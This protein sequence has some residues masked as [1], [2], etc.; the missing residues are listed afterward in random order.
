MT[1]HHDYT[2]TSLSMYKFLKI[3]IAITVWINANA[4]AIPA[5]ISIQQGHMGDVIKLAI[6]TDSKY[7][8]TYG[9]D[10][11][12]IIWDY[13]TSS[14]M[15]FIYVP[16]KVDK[17]QFGE[18]LNNLYYAANNSST[19]YQLTIATME[20]KAVSTAN[21]SF[22]SKTE[23]KLP[24][25]LCKIKGAKITWTEAT[26]LKKIKTLT[27]DY[28]DQPY[29]SLVY[30]KDFDYTIAS[31]KDGSIYVYDKNF[32]L[33]KQLKGHN[34]DVNDIALSPD[35][36][37]LYSVSTD[38]SI[39][40]W[41]LESLTMAERYSG[42]NYPAYGLSLNPS[43][44]KLMY[45]DELG[46]LK[47]VNLSSFKLE[48]TSISESQFPIIHSFQFTDSQYLFAG[49]ANKL[50]V[51][52]DTDKRTT[53]RNAGIG[54]KP[55]IHYLFNEKLGLYQPPFSYYKS[56]DVN[57]TAKLLAVSTDIH[58]IIPGY[59]RLYSLNGNK[60]SNKTRKLYT[61]GESNPATVFFLSDSILF[62]SYS[63]TS[64]KLWKVD[65]AKL[66]PV[67]E[68][69]LKI[70]MA[71]AMV[72]RFSN[73]EL[74]VFNKYE[75]FVHNL[76][77][78]TYSSVGT[79]QPTALF[80][81]ADNLAAY[82]TVQNDFFLVSKAKDSFAVLGPF[83]GHQDNITSI[84]YNPEKQQIY[85]S[86]I[87]GSIKIWDKNNME[88]ILTVVAIG[89][90]N[91]I[92]ITPD[93][94]YM[95]SNK[96]LAS[97]G[98]KKE[99]KFYFPEQFDPIY[100]RPDIVLDRLGYADQTLIDAYYRA[101]QKRLKKLGFTEEML[102]NDF[103][104]PTLEL[105]NIDNIQS[106]TDTASIKLDLNATDTKY[107]LDRINVWVN[108]VAAFGTNGVSVKNA[109]TNKV[110][111]E[112]T[113]SLAK[114]QNKIEVSSVNQAGAES[115]KE[116]FTINCTAGKS[117]PDLYIITI[118]VSTYSDERFN[119]KYAAKDATDMIEAFKNNPSFEKVYAKTLTNQEVTIENIQ[120]L[121]AFLAAADIND[122][123][124]V[125]VAG[126]GLLDSK[127]DYYYA[128]YDMDFKNPETKGIPYEAIED[129]LD[130]IKPL[131]KLL[132]MDTCHSGE[133]DKDDVKETSNSSSNTDVMVRG[134]GIAYLE[135]NENHL[136]L[137]NTSDLM[138]TMFTD[139][140]KGTGAT[141]ISASG[142]LEF[143]LES[144]DW[145][146]GLFTYCLLNGI[147]HQE[148]DLNNDGEIWLQELQQ[149]VFDNVKSLSGGRQTP[150]FR[151]ENRSLNYRIW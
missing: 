20:T 7:F 127:Y 5:D 23:T 73:N 48:N 122:Q 66:K 41:N 45:G 111:K 99:D 6:S 105:K 113:I 64:N 118:G 115:Y 151:L 32:K 82:T 117:K 119:L 8:A 94:Y 63:T 59:V 36:K 109:N 98:F 146:N 40:K 54:V 128:S 107:A 62:T 60:K 145:K 150:T 76:S 57:G 47:T 15:A 69:E 148:A 102:Q 39:I 106:I 125:F 16:I 108:D 67:F 22:I 1:A 65:Q 4:Q 114:G 131:K 112:L 18:S 87:D 12:I 80:G 147:N 34:S 141:V 134:V 136:G 51:D 61:K 88:Q 56:V 132:F 21:I 97:F 95:M 121:K 46:N 70:P 29:T 26:S 49:N 116:A 9:L 138:R 89:N 124:I 58:T 38:R 86:S 137:I 72:S 83:S 10:G 33:K 101:Y 85:T 52:W 96:G 19:L 103:H 17:L 92:Y 79:A 53:Y 110:E 68:K 81:L 55:T 130:G 120:Q 93:N 11:K 144:N 74:L 13:K 140:R 142:G 129:L 84:V 139:L 78:N 143:A 133:V 25:A 2:I 77:T 14:Q 104:L 27:C 35:Q 100:N 42:K 75:L 91:C 30:A 90:S 50:Q 126:H 43:G 28:F 135:S 44:N 123:V 3:V 37:Y 31:S 149:F 71:T 24:N